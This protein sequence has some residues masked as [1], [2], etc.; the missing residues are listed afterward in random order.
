MG[1][2]VTLLSRL[3]WSIRRELSSS[4]SQLYLVRISDTWEH[5]AGSSLRRRNGYRQLYYWHSLK[6]SMGERQ[7]SAGLSYT[8]PLPW[9]R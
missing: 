6:M 7:P 5:V 2:D 8:E 1:K 3:K 9:N 4:S